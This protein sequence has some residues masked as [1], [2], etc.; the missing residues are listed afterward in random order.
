M[1]TLRRLASALA[2]GLVLA[3]GLSPLQGITNASN[4]P[5]APERGGEL[6]AD[7]APQPP[8]QSAENRASEAYG[9]LPLSFE[10]NR[11]QADPR[12]QYLSRG[13]GYGLFLTPTEAVLT[14]SRAAA[15]EPGDRSRPRASDSAAVLRIRLAGANDRAAAAGLDELPG[16][17]SSYVGNDPARWRTG[18]PTFARVRTR[19]STLES[20]SFTTATR[21]SSNTI[22]RSRPGRTPR[23]SGS[24]SRGPGKSASALGETWSWRLTAAAFSPARADCLPGDRRREE[25][26]CGPLRPE[27]GERSRVRLG[28][29]RRGQAL[30]D[31]PAA[32]LLDLPREGAGRTRL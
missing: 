31:R 5:A 8:E 17:V 6:N 23:P 2:L 19:R 11:G 30:S 29:V 22:S 32:G 4:Q 25:S 16:Q 7:S 18:V 27:G 14:L 15:G 21:G 3:V 10:A 24:P 26:G 28:R 12:V 20:T 1:T 9:K 13:S